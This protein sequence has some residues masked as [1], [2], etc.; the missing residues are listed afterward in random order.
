MV[1]SSRAG[2]GLEVVF[3]RELDAPRLVGRI[4]CCGVGAPE[5]GCRLIEVRGVREVERLEPE[6]Q[7]VFFPGHD[8]AF[9]QDEVEVIE[10][11]TIKDVAGGVA[12]NSRRARDKGELVKPLIDGRVVELSA[13]DPVATIASTAILRIDGVN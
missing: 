9:G 5:A 3:Q 4:D 12:V 13:G 10:S 11:R 2:R 6:L 1:A 8:E 7:L